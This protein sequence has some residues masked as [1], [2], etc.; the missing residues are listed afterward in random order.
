[1]PSAAASCRL[2]FPGGRDGDD[3]VFLVISGATSEWILLLLAFYGIGVG[4]DV[5][6]AEDSWSRSVLCSSLG[7]E[8]LCSPWGGFFIRVGGF[9]DGG[10][11]FRLGRSVLPRPYSV[12]LESLVLFLEAVALRSAKQSSWRGG[13]GLLSRIS[14]GFPM[15]GAS[16]FIWPSGADGGGCRCEASSDDA[17]ERRIEEEDEGPLCNSRTM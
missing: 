4:D 9:V 12:C 13:S 15:C 7:I 5:D 10:F 1:M 16:F 6:S 2:P 14:C 17:Q 8:L 3:C 11:L